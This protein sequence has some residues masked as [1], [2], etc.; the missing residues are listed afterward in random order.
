MKHHQHS[1]QIASS[2]LQFGRNLL[3]P[4][5]RSC[6]KRTAGHACAAGEKPHCHI[7]REHHYAMLL[8]LPGAW[9][10]NDKALLPL[11]AAAVHLAHEVFDQ[12]PVPC[13][14]RLV[15]SPMEP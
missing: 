11:N 12:M 4:L 6:H 15:M 9:F 7:N 10:L 1:F 2:L 3:S 5:P 14:E 8:P 13:V